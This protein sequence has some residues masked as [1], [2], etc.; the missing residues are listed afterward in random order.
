[1]KELRIKFM[2]NGKEVERV[3]RFVPAKKYLEYLDLENK[4]MT[5]ES[6]TAAIRK[7]IEFVANLFD[8][9]DVTVENLLNGVPSWELVDVILTTITDMMESPKGSENEGK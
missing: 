5:E 3:Q 4:L 7:K 9:E 1:M 6:F 2:K 8:D